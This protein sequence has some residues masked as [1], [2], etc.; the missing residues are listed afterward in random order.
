MSLAGFNN[1][2]K[3]IIDNSKIDEDLTNFPIAI[4]LSSGTGQTGFD[5][6][7]VFTEL[8][9]TTAES[10]TVFLL[11]M[12]GDASD[13][14]HVVTTNGNPNLYSTTASGMLGSMYF[15]GSGDYLSIADHNDFD[16]GAGDFTVDWWF[17]SDGAFSSQ[18]YFINR[19]LAPSARGW[20]FSYDKSV[21]TIYFSY[22]KVSDPTTYYAKAF[23][24]VDL[25]INTWYH[26]AAVRNGSN[27]HFFIN[28]VEVTDSPYNMGSE[29]LND[30]SRDVYI[31]CYGATVSKG[32]MSEIRIS[33]GIARWTSNF[34]PQTTPYEIDSYTKLL[35]RFEGDRSDSEHV[36]TFLGNPKIYSST[37]KFGGAYYFDG[38]GD[39]L[40]VPDSSDWYFGSEDFTI[41][42]WINFTS[43]ISSQALICQRSS[44]ASDRGWHFHYDGVGTLG[45]KY[46]T[47]TGD[48]TDSYNPSW[49]ASTGVW[50]HMAVVRYGNEINIYING[51]KVGSG[52]D[53]TGDSIVDCAE[54][55]YIAETPYPG[56]ELN[57]YISELN[58]LKGVAKYTSNFIL[59]QGPPGSSWDNRKK[60]AIT[61]SNDNVLFT[62]IERWDYENEEANLWVKIPTITSGT[63]TELY[64]YYDATTSGNTTYVGDTGDAVAQNVWD[65]NFVGVWHMSQDP[66]GGTDA[67]LD[68]TKNINHGTSVGSMIS[69]DLVTGK[70]GKAIEFNGSSQGIRIDSSSNLNPGTGDMT[71][72]AVF[73][74]SDSVNNTYLY[75]NY[76]NNGDRVEF[77]VYA[78]KMRLIVRDDADS[79]RRDGS[80]TVSDDVFHQITAVYTGGVSPT[81]NYYLDGNID[82]GSYDTQ[83][84]S[85]G[86]I[87]PGGTYDYIGMRGA[88]S[89]YFPGIIDE[90]CISN[91][92]RSAAWIK[93]TYYSDWNDLVTF[94][95][96][97]TI[98]FIFSNPI[99][100]PYST[101]YGLAHQLQLT[102]TLTGLD[103]SYIYDATFY[104]AY[105]DSQIE[106]ISGTQSGQ[107]VS[108]YMSTPT[109]ISYSWYVIATSSGQY[110]TS[111]TYTFLNRFMCSGHTQVA[112]TGASGIP[113]RLYRR[114]TGEYV[115]GVI[116]S[117]VSGTFDI[118]TD[119]NENHYAVALYP[120][121]GT[122]ALI[123]D[124]LKPG[125]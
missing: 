27:A 54:P 36:V 90:V 78:G 31:M 117:G 17:K 93:A 35:L 102:T 48:W 68:S 40:T 15:D 98:T 104:D 45:F 46:A 91:I 47:S 106:T 69:D 25:D 38:S 43:I 21:T 19:N 97:G 61:D 96:Y 52:Y 34:T 79:V 83:T 101:M 74:T 85:N 66:S 11:H 100:V 56:E 113:V 60:I 67:V 109:A 7:D 111:D 24:S 84:L 6:T 20:H 26:M 1:A 125:N 64:L 108:T 62:E 110:G 58:I 12:D 72:S 94:N 92:A 37:G 28:G 33:K 2:Y 32:H 50:Y 22:S 103:S 39:Y 4:T 124:W 13:S 44:D 81:I 57:G 16:F 14:Q 5:A 121:S 114:S 70:I 118:P 105:D 122:N 76:E 75:S 88:S 42:F 51:F 3:L 41:E 112:G 119:Y 18:T 86:N 107:Y 71:W 115:G 30:P 23:N 65:D 9:P 49:S 29:A 89:D 82:N 73:K 95:Y 99:P 63:D 77:R 55:L 8:T 123:A 53:C 10:G 80:T 116:S 59:P 87:V 120:T